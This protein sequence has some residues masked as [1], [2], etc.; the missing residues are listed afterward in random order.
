MSRLLAC[1]LLFFAANAWAIDPSE[2][3]PDPEQQAMFESIANEVRCLVCQNQT[4]ADSTAPLAAD[5][6]REIKRMVVEGQSEAEIKDFLVER[7]GDFVLYKPRFRSW[8]LLL[9][10]APAI[11]LIIG[12]VAMINIVRRRT[13]LPI[14]E[15]AP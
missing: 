6:R 12:A 4:I 5:L 10:V 15:D 1:C 9:W 11:F 13:Q 14:D 7:Y 8:N 2:K 3:L